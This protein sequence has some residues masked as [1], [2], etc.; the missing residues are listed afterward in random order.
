MQG[1]DLQGVLGKLEGAFFP[2]CSLQALQAGEATEGETTK[3]RTNIGYFLKTYWILSEYVLDSWILS[4]NVLDIFKKA[5]GSN[6]TCPGLGLPDHR[7]SSL[8]PVKTG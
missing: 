1:T 5:V 6:H 3:N 4:E 2:L 8:P 7:M